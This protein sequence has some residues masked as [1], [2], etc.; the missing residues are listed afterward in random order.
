MKSSWLAHLSEDGRQQSVLEHLRGTAQRSCLYA[1]SF[2]VGEQGELAGLAHDLGKY[3]AA[4]QHRLLQKGP[5]VDHA[6]A[7]AFECLKRGQVFA[8][9]AVAGHHGGLPDGGSRTD[10][11]GTGTFLGRMNKAAKGDLE[12]Y[13]AWQAEVALPDASN[14]AYAVQDKLEGMF[15][16]RMLFSCL[17]DADYAD[18]EAFM[19]GHMAPDCDA[20]S[21][22]ELWRRLQRYISGW[23]P[24]RGALNA[25]R[26][27]IL[28]TCIRQGERRAPGLYTLSVPTG[29]GKT[30]ASLAFALAQAR[31]QK[32]ARVV[33]VVAYTSIIEQTAAVFRE[34]LGANNVLEH[35]SGVCFDLAEDEASTPQTER[36]TRASETWQ[37]PVVVTTAVQFFE[38]LFSCKPSQVRKVHNLAQSV[39]IF[40]EAQM[41]PLSYLRPCVWAITQ[42]VRH[43]GASAVLCTAT[44]PAL[45]SLIR[46]F[47]PELSLEE[48]C[49][50]SAADWEAFRR[51]TFR[52]AGRLDW[53]ALAK[54]L[55]AHRQVLCVLNT[56]KAVR[57][58]FDRLAGEGNFHLSTLMY[59]A[60]RRAVLAEVRRRLE[61]GLPCRLVSTSLIEAGV[62]VDFPALYREEA[63][64]DSLLQAA[65]RCNREGRRSPGESIVVLFQG[66]GRPPRLFET[67]ISAGRMILDRYQD[68]S[69]REAVCDYFTL[70]RDLKGEDAQDSCGIL[71]LMQS[72][73]FPFRTVSERFHLIDSPTVTVYIPAGKAV[74]L[75]ERLRRGEGG[76]GLYR[77][78]GQY[79]VPVYEGHLLALDRAGAIQ[80]LEDGSFVLSDLRR[81]CDKTGLTLEVESGEA[82]FV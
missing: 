55:Q 47:A 56:R 58:V 40:D 8:A 45:G 24:P 60:H 28:E 33:Y 19:R 73:F 5:K 35:H 48:L 49:P 52:R 69:A 72:E 21:I 2:G 62:D 3:T 30:V 76:R 15:F 38:S 70:L 39:L 59:P 11:S 36:F 53:E 50:M 12:A 42:L 80:R 41:L 75:L 32:R 67:A 82:L 10:G 27:A 68:I 29:G 79:G 9:F 78:L 37:V 20:D 22:E 13:D 18:T 7:G 44:Q 16:T 57:E 71:A 63:G 14:P 26:C 34:I 66:E 25:R 43:Y 6:T 64:L 61:D 77:S 1:Q 65:G 4:F 51:V 17:V 46:K 23:F 31:A 74:A 81:Y 54:E